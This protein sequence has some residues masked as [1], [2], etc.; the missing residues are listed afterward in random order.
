MKYIVALVLCLPL[1]GCIHAPQAQHLLGASSMPPPSPAAVASCEKT[2]TWHNVW[3]MSGVVFGG[4]AGAGGGIDA[5]VSNKG[6]QEGMGVTAVV[7]G[8]LAAVSTAAGGFE[9]DTYSTNN[10]AAVLQANA[11]A[12]FNPAPSPTP[13]SP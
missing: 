10:C 1:V 3:T 13:S 4:V 7:A 2:R 9:S 11:N 8:V 6:V 5:A 12:I